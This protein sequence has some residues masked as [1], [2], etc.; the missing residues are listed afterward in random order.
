MKAKGMDKDEE[1]T[2]AT[3]TVKVNEDL[4][5]N[6]IIVNDCYVNGKYVDTPLEDEDD[7]HTI[8]Y[9]KEENKEVELPKTGM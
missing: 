9:T 6:K 2:S 7:A 4:A 5:N 8:V 3:A 1:L